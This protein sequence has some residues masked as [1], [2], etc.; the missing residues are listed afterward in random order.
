[1]SN[2]QREQMHRFVSHLQV[3][4]GCLNELAVPELL[5]RFEEL[6]VDIPQS[7]N[8]VEQL[9]INTLLNKAA[10]R[11]TSAVK[12]E[13]F[14]IDA[15]MNGERFRELIRT[16]RHHVCSRPFWRIADFQEVLGR[17]YS[18]PDLSLAN[19]AVEMRLS[20]SHLT[21]ML[22]RLTG[23]GFS[24][25][26]HEQRARRAMEL[27]THSRLSVK[28]VCARIGYLRTSQF[29]RRFHAFVGMTPSE[30]RAARYEVSR[31]VDF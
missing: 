13:C 28:E 9:A 25:H 26:L 18:Q 31:P 11:L 24:S 29:D 21:R 2:E 3:L 16:L 12:V 8:Q 27:L 30:F 22:R 5:N 23:R 1:M 19:V 15:V 7:A 14:A 17:R 10:S 20:A 6:T 4:A